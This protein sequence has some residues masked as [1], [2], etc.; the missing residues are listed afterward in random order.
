[1]SQPETTTLSKEQQNLV[2]CCDI[3]NIPSPTEPRCLYYW[4]FLPKAS[5]KCTS[6]VSH[7]ELL[8]DEKPEGFQVHDTSVWQHTQSSWD[9]PADQWQSVTAIALGQ[10]HTFSRSS[11]HP[12]AH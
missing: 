2:Y 5:A 4:Q 6:N 3:L 12:A 1:M 8:T 7:A 10:S 11:L 9:H